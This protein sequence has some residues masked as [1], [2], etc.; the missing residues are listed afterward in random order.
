MANADESPYHNLFWIE[1]LHKNDHAEYP[2]FIFPIIRG[3]T[4][5]IT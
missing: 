3:G 2:R 5:D 4:M 1:A